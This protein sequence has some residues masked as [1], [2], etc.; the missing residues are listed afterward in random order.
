MGWHAWGVFE[1][2]TSA[3]RQVLV[4]AQEEARALRHDY[5]GPEHLLLGLLE[6]PEGLGGRILRSL[7][8]AAPVI[9]EKIGLLVG[10]G[11][12]P[13]VGQ[14]PI[15]PRTRA[16]LD[17]AGEEALRLGLNVVETEHLL[18][19]LVADH[20][21]M[22]ARLLR[23]HGQEPARVRREVLLAVSAG[24][25]EEQPSGGPVVTDREIVDEPPR[26]AGD[27]SLWWRSRPIALAGLG[28]AVLARLVFSTSR[29]MG[30]IHFRCRCW[31]GWSLAPKTKPEAETVSWWSLWRAAFDATPTIYATRSR[32]FE[33]KG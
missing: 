21:S 11:E 18:L 15:T 6:V 25:I 7:G 3:A 17:A 8:L 16:V 12:E 28:A 19:G 20:E 30:W 31:S 4:L 9:R 13:S 14:I 2:F 10:A 26:P 29:T 24:S 1:R 32:P 23:D 27:R 5:V 33:I 22:A